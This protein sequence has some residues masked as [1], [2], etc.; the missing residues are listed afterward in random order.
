LLERVVAAIVRDVDAHGSNAQTVTLGDYIDRGPDSRG[1]I[2]RL[3]GNPFPTPY[4][5]LRGNH[6]A[7]LDE[8]LADPSVGP[9]WRS[10][11]GE[12]TLQ[13]YGVAVRHM[14]GRANVQA[15]ELLRAAMPR[16]HVGFL[17]SL[18]MSFTH[19]PF[20]LCHAG[21]RPGVPLD[22]QRDEDLM[23]I[24]EEFLFST[25][26][27]GKIVVHGHTPMP[28]PEVLPNRINIDTKAFAS[29]R[30]TCVVLEPDGYRFLKV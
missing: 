20:F 17:R 23:W 15:A 13:S 27:F 4:V 7:M 29:G 10:Q 1:V 28:E 16:E 18:R 19:G 14:A 26:D 22:K 2:D 3:A 24:R 6:E 9:Q 30:L 8:F 25:A 11:G 5:A 21:V 12:Q